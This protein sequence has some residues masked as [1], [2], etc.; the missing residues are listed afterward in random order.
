MSNNVYAFFIL[1]HTEEYNAALPGACMGSG[2]HDIQPSAWGFAQSH[3][4]YLD[5]PLNLA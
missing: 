2:Q 5:L 3:S 1:L 4:L